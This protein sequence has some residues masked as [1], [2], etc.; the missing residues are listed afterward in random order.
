M[1]SQVITPVQFVPQARDWWRKT[2]GVASGWPAEDICYGLAEHFAEL[3][4]ED[5][6]AFDAVRGRSCVY[7]ANHQVGVESY[8]FSI[9]MSGVA[10]ITTPVVAKPSQ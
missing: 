5:P 10:G 3:V 8:L 7:L 1:A 6:D 4:I 9:V 2:L